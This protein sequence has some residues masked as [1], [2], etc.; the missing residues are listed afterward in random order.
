MLTTDKTR[1][2]LFGLEPGMRDFF[3]S[4]FYGTLE[5]AP[6]DGETGGGVA[7][8]GALLLDVSNKIW[9]QNV[10][11][12]SSPGWLP[13]GGATQKL[14]DDESLRF[15]DK[16]D[17]Y[18]ETIH[19]ARFYYS[20]PKL[21]LEILREDQTSDVY[22]G[23]TIDGG[24]AAG[25]FF[26]HLAAK[27]SRLFKVEGER[28]VTGAVAGGDSN[29]M[30]AEFS[31]TN[32]ALNAPAGHYARGLSVSINNRAAGTITGLQGAFISTRQR[33]DGGAVGHLRGMQLDIVSN[34]GGAAP[35]ANVEGL[36]VEMQL[37]A[38][39]P[40]ASYGVVV[41]NR[42]D[43]NYTE[44]TAAFKAINRGTSGCQGFDYGVDLM[45]A[46]GVDTVRLGEIRLSAQD[47]ND[48]PC[49][50][51]AG[52]ATDDAGIV[53]QV[54]ADTLWADGSLYISAVNGAGAIFQ[55]VADTWT[56]L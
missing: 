30:L 27:K 4:M 40:T 32:R 25:A 12:L 29:D 6:T 54:G 37:E 39:M 51:F 20:D 26:T 55:K 24:D 35:S 21:Y 49:V 22:G 48:L 56:A 46:A 44:P 5:G 1:D 16:T 38:N 53:S 14:R 41:D 2:R 10:N 50:I 19:D 43:G 8:P 33:G 36:R 7:Q 9:Y 28:P 3:E 31:Y 17:A 47:A 52:Q 15:G 18:D 23:F 45:S 13:I 42:T 34:V 11:T